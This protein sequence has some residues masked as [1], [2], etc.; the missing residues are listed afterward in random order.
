MKKNILALFLACLLLLPTGAMM[1]AQ[2]NT[3]PISDPPI[4]LTMYSRM[5]NT[6]SQQMSDLS[7]HTTVQAIEKATGV[8]FE[9]VTPPTGDDGTFLSMI[10]ASG[11]YPDIFFEG[12][13]TYAGGVDGAV[14]DGIIIN[15]NELVEKY[16]PHYMEKYNSLPE[17]LQK[18]MRTAAGMYRLVKFGS[19]ITNGVMNTGLVIR[20][21][22]LSELGLEV[23]K[24]IDEFTNVLRAFKTQKGATVPFAM[25][26]LSDETSSRMDPVAAAYGTK[27]DK[28]YLDENGKVTQSFLAPTYK[29]YLATLR[30]WM[31]EGLIDIDMLG[32]TWSDTLKMTYVGQSG[33]CHTGNWMIKEMLQLGQ[34]ESADYAL[35]PLPVL[36]LNDSDQWIHTSQVQRPVTGSEGVWY[37]SSTCKDPVAAIRFID[38]LYSEEGLTMA[39]WGAGDLGDGTSTYVVKE[40]GSYTFS[41]WILNNPNIPYATLRDKYYLQQWTTRALDD[42]ERIQYSLPLNQQCW[43]TWSYHNDDTQLLPRALGMTAEETSELAGIVNDVD[44]YVMEM[45]Y[46]IITGEEPIENWDAIVSRAKDLGLTRAVEIYQ[47]AYDRYMAD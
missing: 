20:Q 28:F 35:T 4:K 18:G 26:K 46:K 8:E 39:T 32:R 19:D 23:P 30:M 44:T 13:P 36:R 31:E 2:Q 7:E 45:V 29:D 34:T 21:D 38:F 11:E 33:V 16:A 17:N 40:D 22:W 47:T 9:F 12:I 14:E 41:D 5:W 1:E 37:I 6:I 25:A 3:M 43:D 15:H 24:T 42:L 10:I 27:T